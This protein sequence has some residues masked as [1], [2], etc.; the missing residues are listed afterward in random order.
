MLKFYVQICLIPHI[1]WEIDI[2]VPIVKVTNNTYIL[3][4]NADANR[5]ELAMKE[6][7]IPTDRQ[8]NLA[9]RLPYM[10][11]VANIRM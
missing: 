4:E 8:P 6:D 11:P 3:G 1:R 2:P 9:T 5:H 10:A 7:S